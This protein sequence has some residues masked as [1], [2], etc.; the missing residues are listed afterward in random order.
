MCESEDRFYLK[1]EEHEAQ[2]KRMYLDMKAELA[3]KDMIIGSLAKKVKDSEIQ[4][5]KVFRM[6]G[7][8]RI[9]REMQDKQKEICL[10]LQEIVKEP[11][12]MFDI[13][14]TEIPTSLQSKA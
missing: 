13:N 3:A 2:T 11:E 10:D 1:I 12:T 5:R 14:R 7:F 8:P 4:T 9:V 6:V